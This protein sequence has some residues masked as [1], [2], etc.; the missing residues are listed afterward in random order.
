MD[1]N[2]NELNINDRV[3]FVK[4]V[5]GVGSTIEIGGKGTIVNMYS[6]CN[7][8]GGTISVRWDNPKHCWNMHDRIWL[9]TA[10]SLQLQQKSATRFNLLNMN[11]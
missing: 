5:E 7:H 3:M 6:V 2:G 1:I 11:D 8:A 10:R 4:D 9:V